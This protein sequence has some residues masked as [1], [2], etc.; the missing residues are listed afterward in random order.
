M[1]TKQFIVHIESRYE[2]SFISVVLTIRHEIAKFI[3]RCIRNNTCGKAVTR[4]HSMCVVHRRKG[5]N[6]F[7]RQMSWSG[8][9]TRK[10]AAKPK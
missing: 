6:T 8:K 10:T 7:P 5:E 9:M 1:L 3:E 4:N 2:C